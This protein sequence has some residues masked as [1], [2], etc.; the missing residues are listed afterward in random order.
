MP[1]IVGSMNNAEDITALASANDQSGTD[2]V[3]PGYR[4]LPH[5]LEAEQALLGAIL[6]N[7]EAAQ[8]VQSFLM[9]EHFYEPVH[10]RIYQAVITLLDKNQVADP[11]KLKPYFEQDEALSDI[12]GAQ[13]LVRLAAS[14]ATIINAVD[15]G[16]TIYDLALRREII[17]IGSDMVNI[18]YDSDI[19]DEA[20]SQIENAEASLFDLAEKDQSEGGFQEFAR[21]LTTAVENI[22]SAYRDPHSLSGVDTGLQSMNEMIGGMH[23]SDLV[24]LAGRPAMGKTALATNIAFNAA[25][26]WIDDKKAGADMDRTKGAVVGFFSL[27]MSADQLA[28]RI[29][30]DVANRYYEGR[31]TIQS[32]EMRRGKLTQDQFDAIARAAYELEEVPLYIDD[33]PALSI[34]G[35][36]TRAR[37]LKRQKNLGMVVV[38]Y[39]QL[40]RGSGRGTAGESRVQEVSEITRGLKGLAKEL[41]IPVIALSQLS[42]NVESRENKRPMLSDLRESGSIEQ[43]A[44]MVMFVYREEYYKEKERPSDGTDAAATWQ[45][46]MEKLRG[47]AEVVIGK[48]RHG[49]VG[50]IQL[51][52][53]AEVTRF[54]DLAKD[55]YLPDQY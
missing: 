29:L 49:P 8:K 45:A 37:R 52:F 14:A 18:A 21:A 20:T 11:V 34:A 9:A 16:H 27:E 31:E 24:I 33:T 15:Y 7:N 41:Q 26:H 46:E 22:E 25:K 10:G 23:N 39:L 28:G 44:D 32:H 54:S 3:D 6:V 50:T 4:Q 42:R 13:Y 1:P 38:D 35:L 17:N 43:D 55:D 2:K 51:A 5:N 30:A 36:R 47:R 12:G 19:E 40:L 53:H 48:Q